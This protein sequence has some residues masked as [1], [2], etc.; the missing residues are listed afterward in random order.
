MENTHPNEEQPIRWMLHFFTIGVLGWALL[1]GNK[2]NQTANPEQ[3][4]EHLLLLIGLQA[5]YGAVVILGSATYPILRGILQQK[6]NITE[7]DHTAVIAFLYGLA[8][9]GVGYGV[10]LGWENGVIADNNSL[11][12]LIN[13]SMFIFLTRPAMAHIIYKMGI[14]WFVLGLCV[15]LFAFERQRDQ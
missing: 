12:L 13:A 15:M 9:I 2:I 10:Y 14:W 6:T 5:L 7:E 11:L 3:F 4:T 1:E 8:L